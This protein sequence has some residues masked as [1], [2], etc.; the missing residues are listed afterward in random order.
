MPR[1]LTVLYDARCSLCR[2]V[3]RWLSR[4]NQYVPLEFVAGGSAE[5][6]RRFPGLG[7]DRM[8]AELHIVDD[9]G[10]VY[11]GEKAWLM[12][13]WALVDYRSWSVR[14]AKTPHRQRAMRFVQWVAD[15]RT[16]DA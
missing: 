9:A 12:C 16:I 8:L 14:F 3:R 5:S 4:Q 2:R 13:L 6:L 10:Q 1:R 7:A 11:R 15:R